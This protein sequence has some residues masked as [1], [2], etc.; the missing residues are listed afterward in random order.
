MKAIYV[1]LIASLKWNQAKID[2]NAPSTRNRKMIRKTREREENVDKFINTNKFHN[3][4]YTCSSVIWQFHFSHCYDFINSTQSKINGTMINQNDLWFT[5]WAT[6]SKNENVK[7]VEWWHFLPF[8]LFF[9]SRRSVSCLLCCWND[10]FL[11]SFVK[12]FIIIIIKSNCWV[13]CCYAWNQTNCK[14]KIDE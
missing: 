2:C 1:L 8:I 12:V 6:F 11:L 13:E 14:K 7:N 4:Q 5:L 3:S 9:F 10:S